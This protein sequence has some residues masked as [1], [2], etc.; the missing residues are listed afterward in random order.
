[1]KKHLRKYVATGK[2]AESRDLAAGDLRIRKHRVH[3]KRIKKQCVLR[4][5]C[6]G[7]S[8][9]NQSNLNIALQLLIS[10]E[11]T[12]SDLQKAFRNSFTANIGIQ[13]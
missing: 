12:A 4:Y 13:K 1:M 5:F 11:N 9:R 3:L 7:K 6:A 8:L 10:S 2:E